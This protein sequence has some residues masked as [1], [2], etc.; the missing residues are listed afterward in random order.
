MSACVCERGRR[1][2][3][4]CLIK[5]YARDSN[6][7]LT[8][9]AK[10]DVSAHRKPFIKC[11]RFCF[12]SNTKMKT[13]SHIFLG[14]K[15]N[16]PERLF[17]AWTF[18]L[19]GYCR[20]LNTDSQRDGE[21]QRQA[22]ITGSSAA[23]NDIFCPGLS[24]RNGSRGKEEEGETAWQSPHHSPQWECRTAPLPSETFLWIYAGVN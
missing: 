16:P 1:R 5:N 3:S 18:Q 21:W 13:N 10:P 17:L 11:L 8:C 20:H 12:S 14:G 2:Q 4:I 9:E 15:Q 6:Q 19:L 23:F 22:T 7:A 24:K